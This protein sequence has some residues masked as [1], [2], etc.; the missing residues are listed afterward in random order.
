MK[1][2]VQ[3]VAAASVAVE[4][5]VIGSIGQGLAI[6]LGVVEGDTEREADFLAN[7]ITQLRIFTDRQD[8]MNLSVEDMGGE[9]LAVS[10]F[11]LAADCSHGRRPSFTRAAKPQEANGLYE[12]FIAKIGGLLG[13]K[14]QTGQ[15]G[16]DM[17]VTLVN[18]GPVTILLDTDEIMR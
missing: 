3:R 8:K 5:E 9:M 13:K 1:A 15:F 7:K 11:T 16:A 12:Y 2:V 6:L 17:K 4:D 10:Q 18:D 14:T